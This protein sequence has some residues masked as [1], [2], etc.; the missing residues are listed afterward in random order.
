M[1]NGSLIGYGPYAES[2]KADYEEPKQAMFL[3]NNK[4]G[5]TISAPI[6]VT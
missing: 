1:I 5:K 2:I 3:I 6:L 4:Y